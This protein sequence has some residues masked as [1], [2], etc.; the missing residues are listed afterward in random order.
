MSKK[1]SAKDRGYKAAL[2]IALALMLVGSFMASM[3]QSDFGKIEVE[4]IKIATNAGEYISALLFIPPNATAENPAPLIITS[5]GSYNNKEIQDQNFVEWSRRGYVVISMDAYN[6]GSSSIGNHNTGMIDVVEYAYN[7]FDYIDKDKIGISGHSMGGMIS[8]A[9]LK[10]YATQAAL[11]LGPNKIAA[12]LYVGADAAYGGYEVEGIDEIVYPDA[13][14]GIIAGKYDEWFFRS[15]DVA[16]DPARFLESE[17]ARLFVNQVGSDVSGTVESG[18][19]YWGEHEGEAQLR[20]IWQSKEIHPKNHFSTQSAAAGSAFF[21][22]ALGTPN[23]AEYIEPASQVW[24]W[25]EFFNLLG[26]IGAFLFLYP[27]ACLLMETP[28]FGKLKAQKTPARLPAMT[29]GK[30]KAVFWGTYAVNLV[31]PALLVMPIMFK[32]IGKESFVPNNISAWFGE[33]NTNELAGWTLVVAVCIFAVFAISTFAFNKNGKELVSYWGVKTS[34]A[35]FFRSLLLGLAVVTALYV[36]VFF[37]HFCFLTDFRI[38]MI[39]IKPFTLD[40]AVYALAYVPAFFAFYVANSVLVEAGN[41]RENFPNWLVTL[42]SCISN[43]AGISVL[44]AIQYVTLVSK[45]VMRFNSM[46]IVNLFPLIVLIP[47]AT[48]IERFFF[49][50]TGKPYVGAAVISILYTM[51]TCANTMFNA[52]IL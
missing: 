27:F 37:V 45:G 34:V 7:S 30:D 31:L 51:F 50:K 4:E 40:K 24:Q 49:R 9:T 32:L 23:G 41:N 26:L 12:V 35:D 22:E 14:I 20:A 5:H 46:R 15:A 1:S 28:F 8:D 13:N 3:I 17:N 18:K 47:A 25:K 48:V 33:P 19:L 39:A 16:N 36:I 10:H 44:I 2:C 42:L 38:W 43:I 11:G 52:S 6:H 29:T 21:Y